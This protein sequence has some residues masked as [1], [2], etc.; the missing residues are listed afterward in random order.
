V[1]VITFSVDARSR[2][3]SRELRR[4]PRFRAPHRHDVAPALNAAVA[5]GLAA[6]MKL[7]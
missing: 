7:A 3:R 1:D 6:G 4:R 2:L 5:G